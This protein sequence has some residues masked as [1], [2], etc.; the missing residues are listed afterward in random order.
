MFHKLIHEFLHLQILK[1]LLAIIIGIFIGRLYSNSDSSLLYFTNCSTII[2]NKKNLIL[3]TAVKMPLLNIYRFI[4]SARS[5]CNYCDITIF[6]DDV[7]NTDY[8]QLT[9]LYNVLFLS[10]DEYQPKQTNRLSIYSLRFIIYYHYLLN[11][12]YDNIFICD[13]RDTLFQRNIFDEMGLYENK[14]LY[15]FLESEQLSIGGCKFHREWISSCYGQDTLMA[16]YN[17][18][19]ACAG[20]IL[21][22]YKGSTKRR[23]TKLKPRIQNIFV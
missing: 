4:R 14:Q 1:Y 20:T 17:E 5:T 16:L 22:T 10:Y 11:Q 12:Q 21:G 19:R 23:N 3:T 9:L 13:L 6:T 7:D 15:A 18:S 8:K 2:P